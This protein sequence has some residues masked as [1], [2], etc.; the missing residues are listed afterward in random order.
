MYIFIYYIYIFELIVLW[1]T[2]SG[3]HQK[4]LTVYSI[5][6]LIECKVENLKETD[7]SD[8]LK[9]G[10]GIKLKENNVESSC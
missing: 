3:V 1:N 5:V 9:G 10:A 6:P 2:L 7:K 8:F 4:A